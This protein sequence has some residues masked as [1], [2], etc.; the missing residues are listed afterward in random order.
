MLNKRW[1]HLFLTIIPILLLVGC[2]GIREVTMI[3]QAEPYTGPVEVRI[4]SGGVWPSNSPV[5]F[6]M[7]VFT[8]RFGG[9]P[10]QSVLDEVK[11]RGA[12]LGANIVVFQCAAPGTVGGSWCVVRGFRE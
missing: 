5:L 2:A 7:K 3:R 11:A 1:G 8:D 4:A 6:E 12:K 10:S 9:L